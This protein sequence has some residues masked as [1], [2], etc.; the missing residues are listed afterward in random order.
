MFHCCLLQLMRCSLG[1]IS[2]LQTKHVLHSKCLVLQ[3]RKFVSARPCIS[4]DASCLAVSQLK[5]LAVARGFELSSGSLN[6]RSRLRHAF[7][8]LLS[9]TCGM[10][11]YHNEALGEKKSDF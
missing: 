5:V 6:C 9:P 2:K 7:A 8:T 11:E 3:S 4:A 10:A 1:C